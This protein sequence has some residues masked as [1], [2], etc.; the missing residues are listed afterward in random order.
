MRSCV[1]RIWHAGL[2]G[3]RNPRRRTAGL[4]RENHRADNVARENG[5]RLQRTLRSFEQDLGP[6]SSDL[7]QLERQAQ[8]LPPIL[9]PVPRLSAV[10]SRNAAQNV[11]ARLHL[12]GTF[13]ARPKW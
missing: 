6:P 7:Q 10:T 5:L 2:C 3:K 8:Q 11:R 13:Q 12:L 4:K 9:P 1:P